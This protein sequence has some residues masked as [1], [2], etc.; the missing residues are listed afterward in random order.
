MTRCASEHE[1]GS[2]AA[3]DVPGGAWLLDA[4]TSR[5][6]V[7]T[8][9]RCDRQHHRLRSQTIH[10]ARTGVRG[11][12]DGVDQQEIN[13]GIGERA[14]FTID[15]RQ[16]GALGRRLVSIRIAPSRV[17]NLE[18]EL[19]DCAGVNGCGRNPS[20]LADVNEIAHTQAV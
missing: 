13:V 7:V 8:A 18:R 15:R 1:R 16:L 10:M 5:A 9:L 17:D 6:D 3:R 20:T 11:G 4:C 2:A 14:S 12:V 19:T